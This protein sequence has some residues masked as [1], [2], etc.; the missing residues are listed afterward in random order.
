MIRKFLYYITHWEVW[1]W[2]AKY[3]PIFPVWLWYSLRGR[4]FWFFTGSNPTITFGGFLGETKREMYEQLPPETY[5]ASAYVSP[6]EPFSAVQS[7]CKQHQLTYPLAV[8]PDVGM[9]GFMFRK[10]ENEAQL[11]QY[12]AAMEADYIIQDLVNYPLE[13]SV[14]YYRLPGTEK[15][16]ITGFLKKEFL[17]VVGDGSSTLR[18]LIRNYPRVSFRQE[19]MQARHAQRLSDVLPAGEPYCLSYALNLSRGGKLVSLAAEIDDDLL[20]VFDD[21]SHY[22]K[23]FYYGRYDIKCASVEDLKGGKNFSIL[24]YN[25]CG[26]EPHHVYGNGNTLVQAWKILLHHWRM[27]H[28]ISQENYRRGAKIWTYREGKAFMRESKEHFRKLKK[29]DATFELG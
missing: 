29:L 17:E 5:P 4:S 3:V 13:V 18:E 11:R 9:M 25:G 26:A 1:H 21:L 24:E 27:L 16:T 28:R 12:H 15:G 2:Q 22:N 6:Q 7:L 10:I 8:K 23:R 14:F 19:E 20:K